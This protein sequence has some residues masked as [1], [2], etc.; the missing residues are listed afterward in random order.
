MTA[1]EEVALVG[2]LTD[3]ILL[4]L[5][6]QPLAIQQTTLGN[7]VATWLT[8]WIDSAVDKTDPDRLETQIY[9]MLDTVMAIVEDIM[10]VRV[11]ALA[12]ALN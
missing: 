5:Q 2:K 7:V 10:E 4:V 6:P 8:R 12:G 11:R 1:I 9:D 3:E